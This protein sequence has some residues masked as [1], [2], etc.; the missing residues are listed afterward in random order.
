MPV[1][2]LLVGRT[3]SVAG[4]K[5]LPRGIRINYPRCGLGSSCG[6]VVHVAREAAHYLQRAN[7]A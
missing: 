5:A 6:G 1:M 2:D 4:V 3:A 7:I